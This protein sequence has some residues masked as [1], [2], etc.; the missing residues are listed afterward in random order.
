MVDGYQGVA[1]DT[2][3]YQVFSDEVRTF[4]SMTYHTNDMSSKSPTTIPSTSMRRAAMD[5]TS[6]ASTCGYLSVNGPLHPRTA[7]SG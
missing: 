1:M 7:R 3:I 2:H 5:P 4:H 6:P